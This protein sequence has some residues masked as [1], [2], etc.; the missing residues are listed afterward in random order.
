MRYIKQNAWTELK[1][2]M[3]EY[4]PVF[5]LCKVKPAIHLHHCIVSKGKVR[6]KKMHKYLNVIENAL[7]VCEECHK[8]ADAYNVRLMSWQIKCKEFGE[9][10]MDDWY[11]AL[12]FKV[13]EEF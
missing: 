5:K 8:G 13:K 7:P 3:F 2:E 6:N 11:D 9:V 4:R 10:H 1:K 12:P